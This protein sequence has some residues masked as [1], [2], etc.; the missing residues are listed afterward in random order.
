MI[1]TER[2]SSVL[3]WLAAAVVSLQLVL[4]VMRFVLPPAKVDVE[5]LVGPSSP[6]PAAN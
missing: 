5:I 4:L 1:S 2:A 6:V 3:P